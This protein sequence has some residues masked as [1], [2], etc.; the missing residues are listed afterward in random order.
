MLW[1]LA[2]HG[3]EVTQLSG[4]AVAIFRQGLAD[5]FA[6]FWGEVRAVMVATGFGFGAFSQHAQGLSYQTHL[7]LEATAIEAHPQ[8]QPESPA[9]PG[10]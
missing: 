1:Q 10:A 7:S 8:M 5:T 2:L 9:F 4:I 6:R 3:R